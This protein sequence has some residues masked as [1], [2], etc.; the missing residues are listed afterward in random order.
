M[1]RNLTTM[2]KVEQMLK[3][4]RDEMFETSKGIKVINKL[5][6]ESDMIQPPNKLNRKPISRI[7]TKHN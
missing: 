7:R 2:D 5:D 3:D 6:I 1:A 4:L